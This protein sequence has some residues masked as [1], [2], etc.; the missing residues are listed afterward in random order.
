MDQQLINFLSL[1][2]QFEV[3]FSFSFVP[4]LPIAPGSS[5]PCPA[6]IAT[7]LVFFFFGFSFI[8]GVFLL[9][10]F[11]FFLSLFR[12]LDNLS[13]CR[14]W[15]DI[16]N[17]PIFDK[18]QLVVSEKIFTL[19]EFFRS[20]TILDTFGVNWPT[21]ISKIFGSLGFTFVERFFKA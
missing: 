20:I 4:Y 13:S 1:F 14:Y 19:A 17:Q 9:S 18:A 21:R 7:I 3:Q 8:T 2:V 11:V 16:N 10:R 6:S 15:I 12:R 5:P